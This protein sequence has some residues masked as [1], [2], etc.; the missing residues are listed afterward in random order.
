MIQRTG[1]SVKIIIG[2]VGVDVVRHRGGRVA[3]H[4]L[5]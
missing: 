5:N 3:A 4:S 2:E 1:N